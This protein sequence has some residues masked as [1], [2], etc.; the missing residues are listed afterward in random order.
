[1]TRRRGPAESAR[2]WIGYGILT[3]FFGL[4]AAFTPVLEETS[5]IA[6]DRW[7]NARSTTGIPGSR[8]TTLPSI[9]GPVD[10]AHYRAIIALQEAGQFA[11]ADSEIAALDDRLLVGH[12]LAQRYL[13]RAYK[14]QYG[15]LRDWLERYADHP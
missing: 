15:E 4:L 10:V 12:M 3:T 2:T 6:A 7:E 13:H 8:E 5:A 9:L 14:S 11:E 1:M